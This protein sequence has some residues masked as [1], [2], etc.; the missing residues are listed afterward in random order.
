MEEKNGADLLVED[1]ELI[2]DFAF[3][4]RILTK[5]VFIYTLPEVTLIPLQPLLDSLEFPIETDPIG[6]TA[7]GWFFFETN[8]FDLDVKRKILVV[9]NRDVPLPKNA[10]ILS[11]GFDLF[12]ELE[13]LQQ[14]LP[15]KLQ[16]DTGRLRLVISSTQKLPFQ[17]QY[18]RQKIREKI[19]HKKKVDDLP[20]I[21]DKYH[22]LGF[23]TVDVSG[24]G[25][26]GDA[27]GMFY[28]L[29]GSGDV[30]GMESHFSIN[31]ASRDS[32]TRK[33]LRFNKKPNAPDE[34]LYLGVQMFSVGD[35]I[36]P[37]DTLL[38]DGGE[39][40]GV[41]LVFGQLDNETSFGSTIIEGEGTPG[42]EVELYKNGVLI[43]F[44]L[45]EDNGRYRFEDVAVDY[46]ENVFDVRLFGPQGQKENHRKSARVGENMIPVGE[47]AGQISYVEVGKALLDS[48]EKPMK[49]KKLLLQ[50]Q[51]GMTEWL[52][53][54]VSLAA[55]EDE[56]SQATSSQENE[57]FEYVEFSAQGAFPYLALGVDT[58]HNLDKGWGLGLNGQTAVKDSALS[59]FHKHY[60]NFIGDRNPT[61]NLKDEL[62]L[63]LLGFVKREKKSSLS[64]SF[65]LNHNQF[66]KSAATSELENRLGFQAFSGSLSI[67][68][69]AHHVESADS[70]YRGE[71]NYTRSLFRKFSLRSAAFYDLGPS[72]SFNN[73][74]TSLAWQATP[75]I[76]VK[77]GMN[78]GFTSE[79]ANTVDFST[80]ALFDHFTMSLTS[81]FSDQGEKTIMLTFET[82]LAA[83]SARQWSMS[84][85][86]QANNG[87][88]LLR[89][90][91][92][93]DNDGAY[94]LGDAAIPGVEFTGRSDWSN[95]KTD[96]TGSVF[97]SALSA[98]VPTKMAINESSIADPYWKTDFKR[99]K[100]V[101]HA[102]GVNS[103]NVPMFV[104]VE[105]EGSIAIERGER[106][107]AVGGIEVYLSTPNGEIVATTLTEFDGY[108]IFDG[109]APG[110]YEIRFDEQALHHYR[111][112][113]PE[114]IAFVANKHEGVIYIA[115]VLLKA[116]GQLSPLPKH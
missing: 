75:R 81:N 28:S 67:K 42:W 107:K 88:V 18:E 8:R 58:A 9:G 14:W 85:R 83:E 59:F 82:S 5:N 70:R 91:I 48:L 46:G 33:L 76:R 99:A 57:R 32:G 26:A 60:E 56:N 63:R 17:E 37:T 92:D 80:S 109:I 15:L 13:L 106:T 10:V 2:I 16:L 86:Q 84:G 115:P 69:V 22:M 35:I 94:T 111:V 4:N 96:E 62:E 1:Y 11:D 54:G 74:N 36:A 112:G 20:I 25:Q 19:L 7:N 50:W 113:V 53:G 39:G 110:R 3:G 23:P 77:A 55:Y 65:T 98:A 103:I 104:T 40:V 34:D 102:G 78:L 66:E 38:F 114:P 27:D 49:E 87:R 93:N 21:R 30:L 47:S 52:A 6:L 68:T 43:E 71:T 44:Q 41:N 108:Y 31:R 101:S 12:V 89:T 79:S 72:F 64:Y 61:G 90:F 24:G 105:I 29:R 51:K 45:I 73:L 100:V 97:L 95:R 116:A